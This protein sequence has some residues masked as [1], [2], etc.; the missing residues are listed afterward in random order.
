LANQNGAASVV[1]RN[2]TMPIVEMPTVAVTT[3]YIHNTSRLPSTGNRRRTSNSPSN[4]TTAATG[5]E[6]E[7]KSAERYRISLRKT[8][9]H[10]EGASRIPPAAASR[11]DGGSFARFPVV[12]VP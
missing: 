3:A 1:T 12:M 6:L 9:M 11:A 4:T 2:C 5:R 10:T 8:Q 7:A